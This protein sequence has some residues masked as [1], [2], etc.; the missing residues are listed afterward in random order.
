M[1]AIGADVSR[2]KSTT[3]V[4]RPGKEAM[5][6]PFEVSHTDGELI[7]QARGDPKPRR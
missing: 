4:V 6:E 1:K 3:A 2:E 7:D 5:I